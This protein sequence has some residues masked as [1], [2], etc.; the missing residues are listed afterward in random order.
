MTS[1]QFTPKRPLITPDIIKAARLAA[2]LSQ[3]EAARL[4]EVHPDSWASWEAGTHKIPAPVWRLF[5][6]LT[7]KGKP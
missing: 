5:G 7:T 4:C 1:P 6:I 3:A 2:K